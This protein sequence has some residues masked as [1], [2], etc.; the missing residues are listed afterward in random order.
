[1]TARRRSRILEHITAEIS[2]VRQSPLT[3]IWPGAIET[4]TP[5]IVQA[6]DSGDTIHLGADWYARVVPDTVKTCRRPDAPGCSMDL[7]YSTADGPPHVRQ[8]VTI[9]PPRC[10]VRMGG[11]LA[12][13]E[14]D[15]DA[16]VDAVQTAGDV[17]RCAAWCW[18]LHVEA[19]T[20]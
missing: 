1:M 17:E 2:H 14:R 8:R 9:D 16:Y 3:E 7:Y 4:L 15:P 19:I 6:A 13:L 5:L 12:L 11:L 20:P 10:V 18:I